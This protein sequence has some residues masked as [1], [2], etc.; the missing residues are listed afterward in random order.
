MP[1]PGALP[2]LLHQEAAQP[3]RPPPP[4]IPSVA[5]PQLPPPPLQLLRSDAASASPDAAAAALWA[6]CDDPEWARLT[7]GSGWAVDGG[8]GGGEVD[9]DGSAAALGLVLATMR[10]HAGSAECCAAGAEALNTACGPARGAAAKR[11]SERVCSAG[12]LAQCCS[13]MRTHAATEPQLSVVLCDLMACLAAACGNERDAAAAAAEVAAAAAHH[14]AHEG[15]QAASRRARYALSFAT[16]GASTPSSATVVPSSPPAEDAVFDDSDPVAFESLAFSIAAALP[17]PG[18]APHT[19]QR[20]LAGLRRHGEG[21]PSVAAAATAALTATA[22]TGA[23]AC[24]VL[25]NPSAGA[26]APIVALVAAA[27]AEDGSAPDSQVVAAG[28]QA[29]A[30]LGAWA[31]GGAESCE[32]L[33]EA[34]GLSAL[35][36]GMRLQGSPFVQLAAASAHALSSLAV[37]DATQERLL[38]SGTLE[39]CVGRLQETREGVL[40]SAIAALLQSLC[41]GRAAACEAAAAAGAAEVLLLSLARQGGDASCAAA[42]CAAL[43]NLTVSARGRQRVVFA[44]GC[45]VLC[46]LLGSAVGGANSLVVEHALGCLRN[47]ACETEAAEAL[48]LAGAAVCATRALTMHGMNEPEVAEVAAAALA[49]LTAGKCGQP[50]AQPRMPCV[51]VAFRRGHMSI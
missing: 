42:C 26:L 24:A 28:A 49:N 5:A 8:G 9:P 29:A 40:C 25:L 39:D 2:T 17:S 50:L 32:R 35:C 12:G 11:A 15:L 22:S 21:H 51:D 13:A 36:A 1:Q 46:G 3:S 41:A 10:I 43:R 31:E 6:L 37:D 47:L 33:V 18:T 19:V 16:G 48:L 7:S 23:E 27:A 30:C 4:L 44:D 38:S 45:A 14:P 34:G 20:L